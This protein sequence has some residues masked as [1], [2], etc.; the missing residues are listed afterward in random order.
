MANS[1]LTQTLIDGARNSVIKITGIL[2]TSNVAATGTLGASASGATTLGSKTV[3][4]TAGGLT[5]T[6]GQYVTGTGIPSGAYIV[7]FTTT[8]AV[9][10]AAATATGSGLTFTLSAGNIVIID[11]A[12]LLGSP[13]SLRIDHLD[14]SIQDQ[15]EIQLSWDATTP[16]PILPIA[17][18]GRMSFWNFGGLQ[19]NGGTGQTG[20]ILLQT[21]GWSSGTQ[22]FSIILEMV[23]QGNSNG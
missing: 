2:D 3:T 8:S 19:D 17:G 10:S 4:F 5:P 18:R 1:V 15:L 20:R 16:V 22:V 7:S 12:T 6:I 21:T 9:I 13:T 23:K 11:P 14:Y